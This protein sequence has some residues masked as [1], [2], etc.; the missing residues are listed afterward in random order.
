[1]HLYRA[2]PKVKNTSTVQILDGVEFEMD[3]NS[4][5]FPGVKFKPSEGDASGWP[6]DYKLVVKGM[7]FTKEQAQ[8][9][10]R[11]NNS[12]PDAIVNAIKDGKDGFQLYSVHEFGTNPPAAWLKDTGL[13]EIY[14]LTGFVKMIP[15][16]IVRGNG[17][18]V[19]SF[20]E[21]TEMKAQPFYDPGSPATF[22][23]MEFP[24]VTVIP[25]SDVAGA[26]PIFQ[27]TP[28]GVNWTFN[29]ALKTA[30]AG[31][32]HAEIQWL[33]DNKNPNITWVD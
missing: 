13:K 25:N 30:N 8:D 14:D 7:T 16:Y 31:A 3:N 15:N 9:R 21:A 29:N 2:I 18:E 23:V 12:Q 6:E 5:I 4:I 27:T 20:P 26:T 24:K 19:C 32:M 1:M 17:T 33:I 10:F 28:Q 11:L 22:R